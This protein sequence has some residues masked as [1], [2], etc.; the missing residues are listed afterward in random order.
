MSRPVALQGCRSCGS[1]NCEPVIDK[2]TGAPSVS[3]ATALF[4]CR[5]CGEVSI[6]PREVSAVE[7]L[8]AWPATRVPGRHSQHALAVAAWYVVSLLGCG[9]FYYFAP[10]RNSML[11]LIWMGAQIALTAIATMILR[12]TDHPLTA[13]FA[14]SSRLAQYQYF[15]R[16]AQA[17]LLGAAWL[18]FG[19]ALIA[20][21][22]ASL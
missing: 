20:Y 15:T 8:A 13:V 2:Q 22:L 4:R 6:L 9:G 14:S 5:D 11:A 18:L 21:S 16:G 7:S 10:A 17:V 19:G 1:T 3:G 12:T